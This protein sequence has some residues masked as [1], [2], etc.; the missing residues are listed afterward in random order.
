MKKHDSEQT[1]IQLVH[2][3]LEFLDETNEPIDSYE[4]SDFV[5]GEKTAYVEC[6]ELI[7]ERWDKGSENGIP[8]N[9]EKIYPVWPSTKCIGES[10]R[11]N[12]Q[13]VKSP[14]KRTPQSLGSGV[15][16]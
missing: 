5:L 1:L 16:F 3:L 15:F 12:I 9:I 4:N 13:I 6:L 11:V 10:A 7:Q 14:K 8:Q 2:L